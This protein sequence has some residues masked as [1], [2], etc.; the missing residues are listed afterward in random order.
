MTTTRNTTEGEEGDE[1][2]VKNHEAII[3]RYRLIIN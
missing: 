3:Y 1:N 2:S